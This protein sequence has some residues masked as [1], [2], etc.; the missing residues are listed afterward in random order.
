MK[1]KRTNGRKNNLVVGQRV[2]IINKKSRS[3][4]IAGGMRPSGIIH[5]ID[6][7]FKMG[8][9]PRPYQVMLDDLAVNQTTCSYAEGDIV[10]IT[11]LWLMERSS[12]LPY[13]T[14]DPPPPVVA[15]DNHL[16]TLLATAGD[17][18][19]AIDKVKGIS[20][21][22]CAYDGCSVELCDPNKDL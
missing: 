5:K 4:L 21:G 14:G 11:G 6:P 13:Q 1:T 17:M 18:G 9:A 7:S 8:D 20:F 12:S 10:A 16:P 19:I 22:R 15:C 2:A 3:H